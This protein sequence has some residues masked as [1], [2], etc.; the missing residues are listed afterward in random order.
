[1]VVNSLREHLAYLN[2]P[3]SKTY[4]TYHKCSVTIVLCT[5]RSRKWDHLLRPHC[6]T[7]RSILSSAL[8]WHSSSIDP[9]AGSFLLETPPSPDLRTSTPLVFLLCHCPLLLSL[10][11]CPFV[12]SQPLDLAMPQGSVS[13]PFPSFPYTHSLG[14]LI[15]SWLQSTENSYM[16][17]SSPDTFTNSIPIMSYGL[18]DISTGT[19][20]PRS[21]WNICRAE[22]S[23][24]L[25]V[26]TPPIAFLI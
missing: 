23:V 15:S 25:P 16:Y 26:P 2:I 20:S 21:R 5:G 11:V 13:G 24:F 9:A 1:M 3:K 14:D 10:I 19:S 18:L 12:L 4:L 7:Q 8:T 22:L 17:N 6:W